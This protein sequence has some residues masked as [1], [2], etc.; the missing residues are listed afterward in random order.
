MSL[1][2]RAD[3]D[4]RVCHVPRGGM[5]ERRLGK[6]AGAAEQPAK[7]RKTKHLL[8]ARHRRIHRT[9]PT[10]TNRRSSRTALRASS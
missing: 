9:M 2:F 8:H 1:R 3:Q 7:K 5:A 6:V 10:A 4:K